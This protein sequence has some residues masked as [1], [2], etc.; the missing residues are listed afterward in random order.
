MSL[1]ILYAIQDETAV[2]MGGSSDVIFGEKAIFLLRRFSLDCSGMCYLVA[3]C[4]NR[5]EE[6]FSLWEG[7]PKDDDRIQGQVYRKKEENMVQK[8]LNEDRKENHTL[9]KC[10]SCWRCVTQRYLRSHT[11]NSL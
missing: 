11:W 3:L 5:Y 6:V 2:R 8:F 7:E 10:S 9:A 4:A 1:S